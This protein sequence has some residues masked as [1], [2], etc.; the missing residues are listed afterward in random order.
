[1]LFKRY[2]HRCIVSWRPSWILTCMERK[3][4]VNTLFYSHW[5]WVAKIKSF[6]CTVVALNTLTSKYIFFLPFWIWRPFWDL[7]DIFTVCHRAAFNSA[8]NP[9]INAYLILGRAFNMS[10]TILKIISCLISI[11]RSRRRLDIGLTLTL[12]ILFTNQG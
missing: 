6:W 11:L 8:K 3:Y 4:V 10:C 1:M 9:Y 2:C 5:I 7:S 12:E